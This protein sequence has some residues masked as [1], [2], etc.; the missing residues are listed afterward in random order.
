[1]I[2]KYPNRK[3]NRKTNAIWWAMGGAISETGY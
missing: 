2:F 3:T 1:M